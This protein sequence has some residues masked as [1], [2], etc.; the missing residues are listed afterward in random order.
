[1]IYNVTNK[2]F[3]DEVLND[4]K[5]VLVDFNAPMC[6]SCEKISPYLDEIDKENHNAV[7]VVVVN[8]SNEPEL[9]TDNRILN[10]PTLVLF[11]GGKEKGRL[12]G[13]NSKKQILDLINC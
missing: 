11:E 7:K 13:Y 2:N 10:I 3:I 8:I 5:P 12:S 1:M 9:A 6:A 4:E